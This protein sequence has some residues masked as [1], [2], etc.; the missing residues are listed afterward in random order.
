MTSATSAAAANIGKVSRK[1][2]AA[3]RAE[4][5]SLCF[6]CENILS[7]ADPATPPE[8]VSKDPL[9]WS[10]QVQIRR[11]C[12]KFQSIHRL[13]RLAPWLTPVDKGETLIDAF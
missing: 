5:K 12:S 10:G 8:N 6:R 1:D 3:A 7:Y 2:V 4:G 11:P 13:E 9:V